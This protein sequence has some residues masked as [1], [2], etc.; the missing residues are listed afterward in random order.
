MP[1]DL[2]SVP[3]KDLSVENGTRPAKPDLGRVEAPL[4]QPGQ[5]LAAIHRH[6]L[7]DLA[8]IAQVLQRIKAGEA[9]PEDLAHIVLNAEMT[10]NFRAFGTLCG[11]Q[12]RMLSMHHNI[13]ERA[14]FP[15]LHGRG[16]DAMRAV[17]ERLRAEHKVVHELLERLTAAA[18]RLSKAPSE[19][20]FAEAG[21]VFAKLL[22]VVRSHFHYEENALEEALGVYGV[23]I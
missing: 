19:E 7:S 17:V 23:Q 5:H 3:L 11:Q 13:E 15:A 2:R 8:Q 20:T 12:C 4:R 9:P 14:M 16:S 10:Q 18:D 1:S 22:E 21:A 6:Y